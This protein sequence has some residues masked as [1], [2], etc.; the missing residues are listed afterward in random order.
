MVA[1]LLTKVAAL[2]ESK[3]NIIEIADLVLRTAQ[4]EI[5][6]TLIINWVL[7]YIGLIK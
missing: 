3:E 7:V 5:S 1:F 2:R 4:Q 6:F